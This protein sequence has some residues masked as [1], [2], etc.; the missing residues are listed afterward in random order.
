MAVQLPPPALQMPLP[1]P[2]GTR[3]RQ[4]ATAVLR[5]LPGRDV[6]PGGHQAHVRIV[7]YL[8][9]FGFATGAVVSV[10]RL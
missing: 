5:L 10:V 2:F 7:V 3:P 1:V 8:L 4:R 6:A 9:L